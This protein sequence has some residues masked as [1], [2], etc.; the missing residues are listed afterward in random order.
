MVPKKAA[1]EKA[2][3]KKAAAKARAPN[4]K[5]LV[6]TGPKGV[7]K[8]KA[9]TKSVRRSSRLA[10]KEAQGSDHEEVTYTWTTK[11]VAPKHQASQTSPIPQK[12]L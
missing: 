8:A 9:P 6:K 7:V 4:S 2:A 10:K 5:A 11:Y 1:S 3:S 12:S